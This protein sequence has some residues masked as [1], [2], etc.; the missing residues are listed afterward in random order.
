M[1]FVKLY[2]LNL[3]ALDPTPL[4]VQERAHLAYRG[5]VLATRTLM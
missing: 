2:D 5:S 4:V 1:F 3:A